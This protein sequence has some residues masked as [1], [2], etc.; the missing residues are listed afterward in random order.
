MSKKALVTG[1]TGQDGSYLA[2]L[3]LAKRYEVHGIIRRDSSFYTSCFDHLYHYPHESGTKRLLHYGDSS[4]GTQLTNLIYDIS[5]DELYNSGAQS[6]VRIHFDMPEYTGDIVALGSIRLLESPRRS[7][8]KA[9]FYQACGSE[10][11]GAAAPPQSESTPLQPRNPYAATKVYSYWMT[12]TYCKGYGIFDCKGFFFNHAPPGE[13]K[14]VT[15]K[16]SGNL[17]LKT[18]SGINPDGSGKL[19]IDYL[20]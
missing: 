11:F 14:S 1:I 6:H 7:G 2:G 10:M 9:S 16:P 19:R 15:S 3:L 17:P 13:G 4:D 8:I 12:R 18:I 20:S 5:P